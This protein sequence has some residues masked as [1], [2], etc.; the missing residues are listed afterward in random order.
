MPEDALRRPNALLSPR[1]RPEVCRDNPRRPITACVRARGLVELRGAEN[2]DQVKHFVITKAEFSQ[3]HN[4]DS[5]R[6]S[7]RFTVAANTRPVRAVP[8][9]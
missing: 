5:V 7:T 1:W 3:P 4:G 6:G 9:S 2:H 8:P